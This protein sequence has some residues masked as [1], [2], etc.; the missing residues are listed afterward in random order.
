M[1]I[2]ISLVDFFAPSYIELHFLF[3]QIV[4]Q[5][6][7]NQ[8]GSVAVSIGLG[9]AGMDAEGY[10]LTN[11]VKSDRIKRNIV[12]KNGIQKKKNN[13]VG[14]VDYW[15]IPN[16]VSL[17]PLDYIFKFI[18]FI[19]SIPQE[20]NELL[21][22][23]IAI[24]KL[25]DRY[26]SSKNNLTGLITVDVWMEEPELSKAVAEK[27]VEEIKAYVFE[28]EYSN[29]SSQES[30]IEKRLNNVKKDLEKN[31]EELKDF[32][33]KNRN[34]SVLILK[35]DRLKREV[36]INTQIYITLQQELE[37]V[38][39]KLVGQKDPIVLS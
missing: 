33:R 22:E 34:I 5:V 19:L 14:L 26:I 15:G 6:A 29:L 39:I 37:L 11:I 25:S 21:H 18:Y 32:Q 36:S 3:S 30:F 35:E 17:N 12:Q 9:I 23:R 13:P 31:E 8:L 16:R 10:D 38:K 7:W 27:F 4:L 20:P 2:F 28:I 24:N 1:S